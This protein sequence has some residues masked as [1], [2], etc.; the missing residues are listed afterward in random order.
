MEIKLLVEG[1]S[2]KPGPALSQQLGPAGINMGQVISQVNEATSG[3]K[4]LKVPVTLE[5]DTGTKTFEISVASPPMSELIKKEIGLEKGSGLQEKTKV[6]NVAIEQLI[7]V[8]KTKLPNMICRD[9]KAA[10]KEAVGSCVSLGL[11]VE[12]KPATEMA[13]IINSGKYNKEIEGEMTEVDPKK[14]VQ[15]KDF[16]EKYKEEQEKQLAVEQAAAEA[17]EA[18]KEAAKTTAGA[19]EGEAKPEG[20]AGAEAGAEEGKPAEAEKKPEEKK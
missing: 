20:E 5:V 10:V 11:L 8:A 1:G 7:S 16:F 19:V 3:F 17:A 9:L 15:M 6:G 2:M 12:N 14:Q 13:E 18:E 4:G